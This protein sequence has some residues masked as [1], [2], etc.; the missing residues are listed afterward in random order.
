VNDRDADDLWSEPPPRRGWGLAIVLLLLAVAGIAIAVF[1]IKNTQPAAADAT[2]ATEGRLT[3]A[4]DDGQSL[5]IVDRQQSPELWFRVL[6]AEA[7]L[8]ETLS[9][10]CEWV[11][12]DGKVA[13]RNH[14]TTHRIDRQD[15][16]T[17]ARYRLATNAPLG[18]WTVRLQLQG[19]VLQSTTF[20]VQDGGKPAK[21]AP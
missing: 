11:G 13:H 16:P 5:K 21:G 15:W 12:P 2:R 14:Y 4:E 1:V 17:H 9:L 19:R 10:T 7:P 18:N 8:G 6:L 3:L 20:E